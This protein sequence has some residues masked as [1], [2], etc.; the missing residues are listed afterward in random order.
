MPVTRRLTALAGFAGWLYSW[1]FFRALRRDYSIAAP[2]QMPVWLMALM[3]IA[4]TI[5]IAAGLSAAMRARVWP[6]LAVVGG[7]SLF[8]LV[9]L[10]Q[11]AAMQAAPGVSDPSFAQALRAAIKVRAPLAA[12]FWVMG[13]P[14][15]LVVLGIVGLSFRS[16]LESPG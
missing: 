3:A 1:A 10:G 11:L 9:V 6:A 14:S 13:V 4:S 7:A 15:V 5:L 2:G 12:S 16:R 8:L